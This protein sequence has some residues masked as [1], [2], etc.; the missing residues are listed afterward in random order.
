[1]DARRLLI[2]AAVYALSALSAHAADD[3]VIEVE[4]GAFTIEK[5][6]QEARQRRLHGEDFRPVL[7]LQAG[8][9]RLSQPIILRPEDHHTTLIGEPGTVLSGGVRITNWRRQAA[10]FT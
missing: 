8:V 9:Y 1:M 4:A 7:H 3:G 5:A 6:L 2:L 10:F